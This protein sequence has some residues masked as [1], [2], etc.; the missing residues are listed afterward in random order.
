MP[1]SF[2]HNALVDIKIRIIQIIPQSPT[3]KIPINKKRGRLQ[4]PLKKLYDS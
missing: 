3:I 2:S 1:E 4:R